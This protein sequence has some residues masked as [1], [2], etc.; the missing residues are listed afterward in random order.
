M[1]QIANK[2]LMYHSIG[3]GA[4][5]EAGAGLYAAPVEKF[6]KQMAQVY[7]LSKK[8]TITFDDGL[9]DNYKVAFPILKD[10]GLKAYFFVMPEKV[11]T[12]GYMNWDKIRQMRGEG[13]II[14][15]HGMTHRILVGLSDKEGEGVA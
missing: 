8:P 4:L 13:M 15:S 7:E 14:G 2:I 3:D 1:K 12:P 9:V 5:Q 6:V 10:L 11:G